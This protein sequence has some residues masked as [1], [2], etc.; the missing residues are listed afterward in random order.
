VRRGLRRYERATVIAHLK[1]G[2]SL[3]GVL[4]SAHRDCLV[5]SA[6]ESL[7]AGENPVKL[8]GD[9][10]VPMGNVSFL[11]TVVVTG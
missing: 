11:Q 4:A 9:Q 6:A 10:L 2:T 7:S 5:L 8:G 1:D 3:R